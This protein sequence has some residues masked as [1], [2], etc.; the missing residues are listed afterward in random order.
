MTRTGNGEVLETHERAR[1]RVPQV[2]VVRRALGLT[3]EQFSERFRI[4]IGT[5]RD[6]EQRRKEPDQAARAY[7][8]VIATDPDAVTFALGVLPKSDRDQVHQAPDHYGVERVWFV[9]RES[10]DLA[11]TGETIIPRVETEEDA[12]ELAK[13]FA[14]DHPGVR[15]GI[16]YWTPVQVNT[17]TASFLAR[18]DG[19]FS[20]TYEPV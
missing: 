9:Y 4:P 13:Q 17:A 20:E 7:L 2:T 19:S 18:E 10:E 12:I 6:W 8:R 14:V 15:Y 11:Y 5:L 16:G 1:R 3:Q